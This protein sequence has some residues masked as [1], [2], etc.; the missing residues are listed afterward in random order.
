MLEPL[1]KDIILQTSA[2]LPN[3]EVPLSPGLP[4]LQLRKLQL[5]FQNFQKT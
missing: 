4:K 5:S 1:V 3:H 2:S